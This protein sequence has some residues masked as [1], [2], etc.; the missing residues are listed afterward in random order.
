MVTAPTDPSR[1]LRRIYT[2]CQIIPALLLVAYIAGS[3]ILV[4]GRVGEGQS[5]NWDALLPWPVFPVPAWVLIPFAVVSAAIVVPLCL[6]APAATVSRLITA[7]GQ[8][9]AAIAAAAVFAFV[10]PA[11]TGLIPM[12]NDDGSY[13]GAQWIAIPF[14]LFCVVV[15]ITTTIVKGKEYDR[16]RASGALYGDRG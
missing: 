14:L 6:R 2:A 16:L 10:F 3:L 11:D 4:G 13:L 7:V 12:P 9:G 1:T 8:T 15:L 5:E